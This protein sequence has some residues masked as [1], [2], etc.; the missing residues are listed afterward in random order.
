MK[1]VEV[2]TQEVLA[3]SSILASCINALMCRP[4]RHIAVSVH[5]SFPLVSEKGGQPIPDVNL[6]SKQDRLIIGGER[7]SSDPP[8]CPFSVANCF[9][10]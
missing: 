4:N 7:F 1:L 10:T 8:T 9:N 2:K 6:T 5:G 3:C